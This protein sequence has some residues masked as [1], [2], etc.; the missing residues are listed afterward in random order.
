MKTRRDDGIADF[1]LRILDFRL[2]PLEQNI[3]AADCGAF[4]IQNPQSKFQNRLCP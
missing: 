3:D 1:G 4:S 2:K